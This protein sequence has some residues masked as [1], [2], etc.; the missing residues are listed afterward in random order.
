VQLQKSYLDITCII[1]T[2]FT[3]IIIYPLPSMANGQQDHQLFPF[4]YSITTATITTRN[5]INNDIRS[6]STT[7]NSSSA[8]DKKKDN[9]DANAR[10][11]DN[12]DVDDSNNDNSNSNANDND[13]DSVNN[14]NNHST[15]GT[16]SNDNIPKAAILNFYDNDIGQ[17]T[18]TKPILDKYGFK[19]TFL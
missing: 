19:G 8:H 6:D 1:T 18:Y 9:S 2:L 16:S 11:N 17:F 14:V 7:S 12:V 5:Q 4:S 10:D 3:V 13:N 15:Y